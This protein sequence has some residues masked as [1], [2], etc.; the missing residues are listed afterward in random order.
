MDLFSALITFGIGAGATK[1][2][3]RLREHRK[4]P[5]GLA[6]LLGWGFL[7]EEGIVLQKDGSFLAGW[8]YRG[9]D[10]TSS[11][12]MELDVLSK[13]INDALRPYGDNWMFHV[14]A[15]RR[16]ATA[17]APEGAFPDAVTALIDEERRRAYTS[18]R[19]YYETDYYLVATFLP[20]PEL[21]SRLGS[22]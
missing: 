14:D 19:T 21:Y 2:L 10:L 9:P 1:L 16:A 13:H 18:G 4:G 11:T 5:A 7:V 20:P 8:R 3:G 15:V 6:D 12:A 22:L 17:Y